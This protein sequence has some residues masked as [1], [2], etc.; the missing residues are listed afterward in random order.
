MATPLTDMMTIEEHEGVIDIWD[1]MPGEDGWPFK[2]KASDW[3][4]QAWRSRAQF[5]QPV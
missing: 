3:R 2:P 4:W 1:Y 5:P